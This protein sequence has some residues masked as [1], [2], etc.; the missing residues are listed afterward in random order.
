MAVA[1]VP[2][3]EDKVKCK[4]EVDIVSMYDKPKRLEKMNDE[5]WRYFIE[6]AYELEVDV[7]LAEDIIMCESG[8]GAWAKNASSSAHGYFQIIDSTVLSTVRNDPQLNLEVGLR[9][10]KD[11]GSGPW[12][13]SKSCWSGGT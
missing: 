6:R 11:S 1:L 7:E 4:E 10:L 9:L 8:G 13:A 3:Y 12:N 5:D 2:I